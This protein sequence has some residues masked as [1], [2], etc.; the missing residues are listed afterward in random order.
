[1]K[2]YNETSAQL[3]LEPQRMRA[4]QGDLMDSNGPAFQD[5]D[6][7]DFDLA[8]MSMALHHVPDP[9]A[10]LRALVRLLK[11]G[12]RVVIIDWTLDT[13]QDDGTDVVTPQYSTQYPVAYHGF[14]QQQM[15]KLFKEAGCVASDYQ[16]HP[17]P[18]HCPP[19]SNPWR[20]LFFA[21]GEIA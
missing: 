1:M 9:L 13:A 4:V 18:S 20:H 8:V 2:L 7:R 10:M 11:P 14:N 12:G 5:E 21:K 16:V 15:A 6:F 19:M 3:N 17:E